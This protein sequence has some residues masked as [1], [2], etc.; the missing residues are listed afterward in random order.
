M[1][2]PIA[3]L[4]SFFA[5]RLGNRDLT[6]DESLALAGDLAGRPDLWR[7]LVRHSDDERIA[8]PGQR[9]RQLPRSIRKPLASE[10]I[11]HKP[12]GHTHCREAKSDMESDSRLQ[13][14]REQRTELGCCGP[15]DARRLRHRR[16][17]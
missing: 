13:Q 10:R 16:H 1:N 8:V 7:Q 17:G 15:G 14:P 12:G 5:E 6:P 2:D 4:Q 3:G 9:V 11:L